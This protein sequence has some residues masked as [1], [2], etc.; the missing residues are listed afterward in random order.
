MD[1][2]KRLWY[3]NRFELEFMKRRGNAFQDFFSDIMER[4]YP[5]DFMRTRPWGKLGDRKN[6]GYLASQRCLFQVYAP[7]EMAHKEALKKIDEDFQGALP[8][9]QKYYDIWVFTHNA[10]NG[11]GP[12]IL[13]KLLHLDE[14]NRP[15]RVIHCGFPELLQHFRKLNEADLAAL[16]GPC[17]SIHDVQQLRVVDLQIVLQTI[18]RGAEALNR[19]VRPVPPQKLAANA[20][21]FAV[22]SYLQLG[23]IKT[24]LLR[25]FFAQWH[26][27]RYGDQLADTFRQQYEELRKQGLTPDDI[28][29]KL[30][31]FVIGDARG[32]PTQEIAALTVLAYFFE[33]CDIFEEPRGES[34]G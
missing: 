8:Y 9:W 24:D 12:H 32:K 20:F 7:D 3:E 4:C 2:V 10:R 21:S 33:A 1:E 19:D 28:F 23:M 13:E 16:F 22:Q 6:D 11:L 5:G 27:P 17:P 26:D 14:N 15:L 30:Q 25:T 18:E 31:A 34:S 29:W